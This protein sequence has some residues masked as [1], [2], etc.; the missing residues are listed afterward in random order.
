[1]SDVGPH[2]TAPSQITTERTL[3]S[4]TTQQPVTVWAFIGRSADQHLM[5][6]REEAPGCSKRHAR[7]CFSHK[8]IWLFI[9]AVA[10]PHR[11]SETTHLSPLMWVKWVL[12]KCIHWSFNAVVSK[13]FTRTNL[14][15][16]W[17]YKEQTR[18]TLDYDRSRKGPN[19]HESIIK[20]EK[21]R[22]KPTKEQLKT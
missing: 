21:T 8:S 14:L 18:L 13:Y 9:C 22:A 20:V 12:Q 1:M 11:R 2:P 19:L 7:L 17:L 5:N 4:S 16:S 6:Q 3:S 10:L 15:N